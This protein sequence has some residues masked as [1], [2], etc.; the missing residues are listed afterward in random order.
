MSY[1]SA[2]CVIL[3]QSTLSGIDL[4]S[5]TV[6]DKGKEEAETVSRTED[7]SLKKGAPTI[8]VCICV[9]I[10]DSVAPPHTT[11]T[12]HKRAEHL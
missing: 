10:S 4:D 5:S 11:Y 7:A 8:S 12:I 2:V 9:S 1:F 6:K 3:L